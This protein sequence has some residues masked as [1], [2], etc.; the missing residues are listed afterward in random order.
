[1]L[2][3]VKKDVENE[4]GKKTEYEIFSDMTERQRVLYNTIKEKLTSISDLFTSVDSK[5]K[6]ENLMNLVMQFRKVCNH[7]ELFERNIGKVPLAFRDLRFARTATFIKSD[8]ITEVWT[9]NKNCIKFNI[10]KLV[11]DN[12]INDTTS[13]KLYNLHNYQNVI[14]SVKDI[15]KGQFNGLYS[16]VTMFNF[17]INE[18]LN[19]LKMDSLIAQIC[20]IHYLKEKSVKNNYYTMFNNEDN[21]S[22]APFARFNS[23]FYVGIKEDINSNNSIR[24]VGGL[25]ILLCNKYLSDE[26]SYLFKRQFFN[27]SSLI[28]ESFTLIKDNCLFKEIKVFQLLNKNIEA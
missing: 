11:F 14:S 10:P 24:N 28:Q 27:H 3:R 17:S 12:A 8:N 26:Y 1:M 7:P 23:N 15:Y 20:L 2:R 9:D 6:V 16:F 25:N 19:L 18:F 5:S 21:F 13:G 22:I 4:I